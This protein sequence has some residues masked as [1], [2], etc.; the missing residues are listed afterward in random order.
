TRSN[1]AWPAASPTF[2]AYAPW[3]CASRKRALTTMIGCG[4]PVATTV[5]CTVFSLSPRVG[6][7]ASTIGTSFFGSGKAS[8]TCRGAGRR[9]AGELTGGPLG[10]DLPLLQHV[11]PLGVGQGEMHELLHDEDGGPGPVHLLEDVEEVLDHDRGKAEREL[12][13]QEQAGRGHERAADGQ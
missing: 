9:V 8:S 12:V 1:S 3:F 2:A 11:G 10:D 13:D 4:W 6:L 5:M 7:I